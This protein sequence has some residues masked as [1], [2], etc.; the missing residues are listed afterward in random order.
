MTTETQ[1]VRIF[2]VRFAKNLGKV[3]AFI[4][5]AGAFSFGGTALIM[6]PALVGVYVELGLLPWEL[7][8][9][10]SDISVYWYGLMLAWWIVLAAGAKS[11]RETRRQLVSG[12]A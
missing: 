5:G 1:A 2:G 9:A 10:S 4:V 6:A 8:E 11:A 7:L 3:V 12:M